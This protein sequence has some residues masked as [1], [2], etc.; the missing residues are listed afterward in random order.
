MNIYLG[1]E[2]ISIGGKVEFIKCSACNFESFRLEL[3][4]DTDMVYKEV[5]GFV[6]KEHKELLLTHV[7]DEEFHNFSNYSGNELS[8]RVNTVFKGNGF[9]FYKSKHFTDQNGEEYWA[10]VCPKCESSFQTERKI[11][12]EDFIKEGGKVI[13]YSLY[14]KFY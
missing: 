10:P 13:T 2:N 7:S 5:I 14:D 4:A 11:S 8:E 9:T 12:L 3:S 1:S 6:N